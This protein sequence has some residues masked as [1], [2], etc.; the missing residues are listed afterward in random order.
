MHHNHV[1]QK[2]MR[3]QRREMIINDTA[4]SKTFRITF[5]P[6]FRTIIDLEAF[7]TQP[8]Y[9]TF[10]NHFPPVS[11]NWKTETWSYI[12]F[13][14]LAEY[15]HHHLKHP[16][17]PNVH[18]ETI[19][20]YLALLERLTPGIRT[21]ET[22]INR[23]DCTL[24]TW[25][26]YLTTYLAQC[27]EHLIDHR[28]L[29]AWI[30]RATQ[31]DLIPAFGQFIARHCLLLLTYC[32]EGIETY[33]RFNVP[34]AERVRTHPALQILSD[35]YYAI[36]L[37]SFSLYGMR[38]VDLHTPLSPHVL[39]STSPDTERWLSLKPYI[40]DLNALPEVHEALSFL[41]QGRIQPLP[42]GAYPL[43]IFLG[44]AIELGT[45]VPLRL[46][47]SLSVFLIDL[48]TCGQL[49]FLSAIEQTLS[50]AH[51]Q[52]SPLT[53]AKQ[54]CYRRYT[55]EHAVLEVMHQ[56]INSLYD[57]LCNQITGTKLAKTVR[58]TLHELTHNI[59]YTVTDPWDMLKIYGQAA[60]LAK[61][62]RILEQLRRTLQ[63]QHNHILTDL[64]QKCRTLPSTDILTSG[65][66]PNTPAL[67]WSA[68]VN[69][70]FNQFHTLLDF[71]DEIVAG[72]MTLLIN[73][74][75]RKSPEVAIPYFMLSQ[76]S[77][78][79]LLVYGN[80]P[81]TVLIP[82]YE[83][84][85]WISL[86][87]TGVSVDETI[88][89]QFI[90]VFM[91][92]K[93]S[94]FT[95]EAMINLVQGE[96]GLLRKIFHQ[97]ET[98]LL[99][100]MVLITAGS[101]LQFIP[102]LPT[103][104]TL[105][106]LSLPNPYT[107]LLTFFAE[108]S[109]RASQN[110]TAPFTA[111]E[112]AF[113]GLKFFILGYF[114]LSGAHK[115][116]RIPFETERFYRTVQSAQ[117]TE[118]AVE[119]ALSAQQI[120]Q[121]PDKTD[122][123]FV[124]WQQRL[125][126][127]M[128]RERS[129]ESTLC[130]I[131]NP[132]RATALSHTHHALMELVTQIRW[133]ELLKLSLTREQAAHISDAL[134]ER[135]ACYNQAVLAIGR[136]DKLIQI[137]PLFTSFYNRHYHLGTTVLYQCISLYPLL[138]LTLLWRSALKK[139]ARTKT[140]SSLTLCHQIDKGNATFTALAYQLLAMINLTLQALAL[141]YWSLCTTLLAPIISGNNRLHTYL[142][143]LNCTTA[144]LTQPLHPHYVHAA[145]IARTNDEALVPTT[146]H[147]LTQLKHDTPDY[148]EQT[149]L[150]IDQQIVLVYRNASPD[151]QK[152]LTKLVEMVHHQ[153]EPT[154]ALAFFTQH[155]GLAAEFPELFAEIQHRVPPPSVSSAGANSCHPRES[156]QDYSEQQST[157]RTSLYIDTP[158][159]VPV[160]DSNDYSAF[161]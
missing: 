146:V 145:D 66:L 98:I 132:S 42:H 7:L 110:G 12:L 69:A 116:K 56:H 41:T 103:Y 11:R 44:N 142:N 119:I 40:S 52:L 117:C 74:M 81:P 149:A 79:T 25:K 48:M 136:L 152:V 59:L 31:S 5:D 51:Q 29:Y 123:L 159:H 32:Q 76:I 22:L 47:S 111:L 86:K 143:R 118:T 89:S 65:L 93:L 54:V 147:L 120:E 92:W 135:A 90:A 107:A 61:Q 77:L 8:E 114:L 62:T 18:D 97:P 10:L 36:E 13:T 39:T 80:Q 70:P 72:L 73:P 34:Y 16:H 37:K 43:F 158:A 91:M 55:A 160:D 33:L 102:A 133:I 1:P 49:S 105:G 82:F 26:A 156:F 124:T 150:A 78:V 137:E 121:V 3:K 46:T 126:Q 84:P 140:F 161:V 113:L 75:F 17:T 30:E 67:R 27:N 21:L 131:P 115:P 138:P 106:S 28:T 19:A 68:M 134:L 130:L 148:F 63:N 144:N 2:R 35:A 139:L 95:T 20:D 24:E 108:E 155:P 50:Q 38:Y 96:W 71:V 151:E 129:T 141:A 85:A 58:Y 128:R 122:E 100:L 153:T 94:F 9:L 101:T 64:A 14:A 53:C 60:R 125:F 23:T 112:L 83:I 99:G 87:F 154:Q 127:T 45:L 109:R 4:S 104:V 88:A 15:Q 157:P 6:T 57:T